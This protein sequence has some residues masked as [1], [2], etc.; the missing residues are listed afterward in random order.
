[1][2]AVFGQTGS[3]QGGRVTTGRRGPS[4]LDTVFVLVCGLVVRKKLKNM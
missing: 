3:W 2:T 1:M 4:L